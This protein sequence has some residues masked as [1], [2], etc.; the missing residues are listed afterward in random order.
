M[1]EYFLRKVRFNIAPTIKNP[2]KVRWS[3]RGDQTFLI[4]R[5]IQPWWYSNSSFK[6][7]RTKSGQKIKYS[8][9]VWGRASSSNIIEVEKI[10]SPC[11]QQAKK[12]AA[13]EVSRQSRLSTEHVLMFHEDLK[14]SS[15]RRWPLCRLLLKYYVQ[16]LKLAILFYH[17]F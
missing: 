15:H 2:K 13:T 4:P 10:C 9:L 11:F 17:Q 6:N 12:K 1:F 14:I 7:S 16:V 5:R 8:Y 3:E